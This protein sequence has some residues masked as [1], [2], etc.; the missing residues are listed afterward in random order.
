M[1]LPSTRLLV[2]P[3]TPVVLQFVIMSK[4][5]SILTEQFKVLIA[6]HY[7]STLNCYDVS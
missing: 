5:S 7:R 2:S 6:L 4:D 1:D 3:Q